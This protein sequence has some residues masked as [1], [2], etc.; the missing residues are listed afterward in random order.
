MEGHEIA[1]PV[2]TGLVCTDAV[3][4]QVD[5]SPDLFTLVRFGC[6]FYD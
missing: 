1:D 2:L 5:H 3:V 4:M 6:A